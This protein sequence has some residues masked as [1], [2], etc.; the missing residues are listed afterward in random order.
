[1]KRTPLKKVS[2]KQRAELTKRRKVRAELEVIAGGRCQHCGR[3]PDWR[4]LQMHHKIPLS[5]GG[6][7]SVENCELWAAPCHFG[8]DGHRIE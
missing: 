1:M 4:G 3:L 5:Q 7:T 2:T 8:P 6:E